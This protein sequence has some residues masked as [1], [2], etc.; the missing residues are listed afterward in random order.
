VIN[1]AELQEPS[2]DLPWD[3]YLR[4]DLRELVKCSRIA[5]LPD[6]QQSRGAQLELHVAEALGMQVI[7]PHNIRMLL[8]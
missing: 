7:L 8:P 3:W 2:P 6:W 5:L 1:P 4:R